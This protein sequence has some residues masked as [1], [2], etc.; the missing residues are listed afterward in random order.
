MKHLIKLISIL[1]LSSTLSFGQ[2]LAKVSLDYK[3]RNLKEGN[4]P[5]KWEDGMRTT[6]EKGTYEWWYFD[7][8]LHDGSTAVIV[9]YTKPMIESKK[10]LSPYV[11]V[12][13]DKKD[14]SKISKSFHFDSEDF[15]SSKD[16]CN[17]KMG[18]NYVVGNLKYYEIHI[19]G[20]DINLTAKIKRT[21]ESWRPQ[22]GHMVFGKEESKEFNWV[23]SVPKGEMDLEYDFKGEKTETNGSVYHDHNWGNV[24]MT[25]LFNHWYWSRAEIGPY[26]VIASE[27]IS[28]KDF[29]NENIIVFN[30]SKDGKTLVDDGKK[31]TLFRSYGKLHPEL[32]KDVSDDLIFV[33]DDEESGYRYE[34]TLQ[35]K[36]TIMEVDFIKSAVGSGLKYH[37]AR[38]VTSI[39]PAYLRFTGNAEIKVF[40]DDQFVEKH[41]SNKAVWELMYFGYPVGK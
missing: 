21:T 34:Y 33:Y 11:T 27:M 26:N 17:I 6:G 40:K 20:E 38:M 31:V 36:N 24:S 7:G 23:V 15:F 16:S 32:K 25:E 2:D 14:G 41:T 22:T 29:N 35:R 12:D 13:I 1:F 18:N 3:K 39:D 37:L 30:I 9:F 28:E 10:S 19:E 5:E 8:H 4:I